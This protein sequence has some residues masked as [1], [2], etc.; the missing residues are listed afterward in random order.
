M[1]NNTSI[2]LIDKQLERGINYDNVCGQ[3]LWNDSFFWNRKQ[4]MEVK[5]FQFY[6]FIVVLY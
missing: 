3:Q 1:T 4:N 5:V 2:I 6:L